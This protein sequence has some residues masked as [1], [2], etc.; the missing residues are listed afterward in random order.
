ML[1]PSSSQEQTTNL[2]SA[3]S[4]LNPQLTLRP[5]D[6]Q[7]NLSLKIVSDKEASRISHMKSSDY[8]QSTSSHKEIMFAG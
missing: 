7:Y 2:N 1:P 3:S 4:L 5:L 6:Y 8:F